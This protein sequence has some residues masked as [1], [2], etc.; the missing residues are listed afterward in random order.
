MRSGEKQARRSRALGIGG[1]TRL[2]S[3]RFGGPHVDALGKVTWSERPRFRPDGGRPRCSQ[4]LDIYVC[5]NFDLQH[6]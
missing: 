4:T 3:E 1:F 2:I 5:A 6:L